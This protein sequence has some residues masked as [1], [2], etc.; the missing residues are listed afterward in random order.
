MPSITIKIPIKEIWLNEDDFD[1]YEVIEFEYEYDV[2]VLHRVL[3]EFFA[4][5]YSIS[6]EKA[7]EIA[8]DF[9]LWDYL[10]HYFDNGNLLDRLQQE[11]YYEALEYYN[12]NY[13]D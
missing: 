9:D 1:G 12:N 6:L 7:T 13:N 4:D 2:E 3:I 8:N 10:L 5:E 11:L